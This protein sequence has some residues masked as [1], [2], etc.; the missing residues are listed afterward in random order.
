VRVLRVRYGD[1][2]A[3]DLVQETYLRAASLQSLA[4]IASPRGLLLRIA[5]NVAIDQ[6][7]RASVRPV[8][9]RTP[10]AEVALERRGVES[11]QSERLALKQIILSLPPKLRDVFVLSR[12][13]GLTYDEIGVRLGISAKTVEGR[14]TKAL[15]I[16]AAKI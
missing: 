3:D 10:E 8:A 13:T 2:L 6:H 1:D 9:G 14:M 11:D 4:N 16:C 7:R 15:R 12:F 5:A